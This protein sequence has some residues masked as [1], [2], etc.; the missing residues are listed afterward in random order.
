M[1][2]TFEFIPDQALGDALRNARKTI[3][4]G[5]ATAFLR[6]VLATALIDETARSLPEVER[7]H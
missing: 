7:R 4:A 2:D 5:D 3:L 1:F 6:H